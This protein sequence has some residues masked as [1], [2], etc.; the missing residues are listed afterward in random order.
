MKLLR[1]WPREVITVVALG[2]LLLA[3]L[4]VIILA[5]GSSDKPRPLN[6]ALQ[7]SLTADYSAALGRTA[8]PAARL[9]L[10]ADTLNDALIGDETLPTRVAVVRESLQTPVPTV[11]LAPSQTA[12]AAVLSPTPTPSASETFLPASTNTATPTEV[13][14]ATATPSRTATL[15]VTGTPRATRSAMPTPSASASATVTATATATPTPSRTL[16]ATLTAM[17]TA[18]LTATLTDTPTSTLRPGATPSTTP[19]VSP[20]PI[21]SA[22]PTA[23]PTAT[24]T[25]TPRPS[26]TPSLEPT[27]TWTPLPTAT[28]TLVP[29]PTT[30]PPT[31]TATP[32]CALSASALNLAGDEL[33]TDV[34]NAG[35]L[36]ATLIRLSATWVDDPSSQALRRIELSG[37]QIF[38]GTDP[39]SPSTLPDERNW[40]GAPADRQFGPN[41]SRDLRL[42]FR[43]PLAPGAY[44]L[45][46]EFD[47][48]CSVTTDN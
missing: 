30:E 11:T 29:S 21:P 25:L 40:D 38:S 9:S 7:S 23:T 8:I 10:I 48:G 41:S 14:S 28:N 43:E 34:T 6:I 13:A 1:P 12:I 5:E 22:T 18:T 4:T 45:T 33:R 24:R 27:L 15:S 16:T 2:F 47:N 35:P 36:A 37:L 19:S 32:G 17:L 3:L 44:S 26:A 39:D 31:L 46:L 42:E 20:T